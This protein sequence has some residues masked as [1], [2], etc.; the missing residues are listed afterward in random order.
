MTLDDDELQVYLKKTLAY[1]CLQEVEMCDLFDFD[2]CE[3]NSLKA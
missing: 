2:T 3:E 1:E